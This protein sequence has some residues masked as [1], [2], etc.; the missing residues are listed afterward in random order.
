LQK[1]VFNK[2]RE[3]VRGERG[4]KREWGEKREEGRLTLVIGFT[5]AALYIF[6]IW[7][8]KHERALRMAIF[9]SST[10]CSGLF[11]GL[12]A[13]G[14]LQMEGIVCKKKEEKKRKN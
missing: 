9:F 5:P 2:K 1:L 12:L 6:T 14:I 10:A 3:G 11:G 8:T 13:Y 7:F 4:R